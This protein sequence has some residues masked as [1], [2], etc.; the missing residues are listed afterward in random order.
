MNSKMRLAA[1]CTAVKRAKE[2]REEPSRLL[3]FLK[4]PVITISS[5]LTHTHMYICIHM[6]IYIY[7][8][9]TFRVLFA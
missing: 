3:A 9:D 2:D 5:T 6:Y 4:M 8:A 7:V 1:R